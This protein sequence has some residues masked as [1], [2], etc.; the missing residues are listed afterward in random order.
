[1]DLAWKWSRTREL[2][3]RFQA[4][5]LQ[6]FDRNREHPLDIYNESLTCLPLRY[7]MIFMI[8]GI[9][10]NWI[11]AFNIN[12]EYVRTNWQPD[13]LA[14]YL[15][16]CDKIKYACDVFPS[17]YV[18]AH[19]ELN[20]QHP[21]WCGHAYSRPDSER[22]ES[23]FVRE[24]LCRKTLNNILETALH[25]NEPGEFPNHCYC[26]D[27]DAIA[28]VRGAV[29]NP[30]IEMKHLEWIE[31]CQFFVG[32]DYLF[33]SLIKNEFVRPGVHDDRQ[34]IIEAARATR[35]LPNVL[36]RLVFDFA[37]RHG[38][39]SSDFLKYWMGSPSAPQEN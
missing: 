38:V 32:H 22:K 15:L 10:E 16:M 33:S 9:P 35:A 13:I 17:E 19:P 20:I 5:L 8:A 4:Y 37:W 18:A 7:R 21:S 29:K 24:T 23:G 27:D 28:I 6:E 34:C 26:M 14:A 31:K 3:D 11:R 1:M 36:R 39:E 12:H 30:L 25:V 2:L